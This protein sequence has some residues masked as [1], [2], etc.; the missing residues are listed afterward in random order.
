[1]EI[2]L[3]SG[4]G[5]FG[6]LYNQQNRQKN[7][8]NENSKGL[9]EES[10]KYPIFKGPEYSNIAGCPASYP[11]MYNSAVMPPMQSMD[12]NYI[13]FM[14]DQYIK[15][16]K[17]NNM[18]KNEEK[19]VGNYRKE[20]FTSAS[21]DHE[22]GPILGQGSQ[23]M[24]SMNSYIPSNDPTSE[25]LLDL[26]KRP[27]T[28][29]S[30]NNMM[31]FFGSK[32]TQNM[33]GTGVAQGN[34]IDGVTVDTGFDKSTPYQ[35]KLASFTGMDDNYLHKR[36]AGPM[37]SPG[38]QQTGWVYGTPLF[39]E[40]IGRYTDS[41]TTRN[42]LRPVESEQVGPGLNLDPSIPAAGGFHEFTRVMPNNVSDYKAN[43]L[44]GR[45]NEGKFYSAGLPTSYPGIGTENNANGNAPGVPKNRPPKDFSQTRYPTMTT[46]VG[47][48][49][50]AE[51]MRGD[52]DVDKRP[53]N[54]LRDQISYGYGTIKPV[55]TENFQNTD[56]VV[57]KPAYKAFQSS[58]SSDK[59]CVEPEMPVGI[60]PSIPTKQ[61]P[62]RSPTFM[63]QDNNIRSVSDCNSIPVIG[64]SLERHSM[65]P[66]LS[67][68]Y[69]NETGRGTVAPENVSQL[70][71]KGVDLFNNLSYRDPQKVT[72][73]ETTQFNYQGNP[74]IQD[75]QGKFY[76]YV[77]DPSVTTKETTQ[78]NYQ[79]NPNIQDK[80]GKFYTYTDLPK[81]T[82]KET[83]EFSYAGDPN[84]GLT[85][86][87]ETSRF[88]YTGP[89]DGKELFGNVDYND[90]KKMNSMG[91]KNKI[92]G[93]KTYSIKSST[94]VQDYF[95]G[96]GR[97]NILQDPDE[98]LGKIKFN[99]SDRNY[100]GP[101]TI[102]QAIP[103]ATYQQN[104]RYMA[105]PKPAANKLFGIN[106]R[107]LASYQ[108]EH[109][110]D[111]PLSMYTVNPNGE[112]P[113]FFQDNKPDDYSSLIQENKKN[114]IERVK[115][116]DNSGDFGIAVNVYPKGGSVLNNSQNNA[117]AKVVYNEISE[118]SSDS[119]SNNYN[120]M[121][122]QGSS[123]RTNTDPTFSGHAYSGEFST[124]KKNPQ[125]K[126]LLDPNGVVY[127]PNK[128]VPM[129]S[130]DFGME[131]GP[132]NT[133]NGQEVC[134]PSKPLYFTSEL[135]LNRDFR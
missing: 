119:V 99:K 30:H 23:L 79:G 5:L 9:Q 71:L 95:P 100:T 118:L 24:N 127:T 41:L 34:Y 116:V 1:M 104:N 62:T 48:V 13:K 15:Q 84:A 113:K 35:T 108:V 134:K 111:N 59:Y 83:A 88:Q 11:G 67:N 32:V 107:S 112:I 76:T 135:E 110:R 22:S 49:Q 44:E 114:I 93:A 78:F 28:D 66:I 124:D 31:P 54:A 55:N 33:A 8:Q 6:Y 132:I 89:T 47:F 19:M 39:R 133:P 36:E 37:Y 82:T 86:F 26:K 12:P 50:N 20:N 97:Q 7:F 94:L 60:S 64:P 75:K 90:L 69:V 58:K 53:K 43:Q 56:S 120:P 105:T 130:N 73:K 101:G 70:N 91:P 121:I 21:I 27:E 42:D 3:L 57:S 18:R 92:G 85:A 131:N 10:N 68:Y 106:D 65:G 109:L 125:E 16:Q 38:E 40:D 25:Y 122:S 129:Q 98:L 45:V 72:T 115:N 103:S 17:I 46:K 51:E 123:T 128:N 61:G 74:N 29:A 96:A 80:Q 87:R 117:N 77:D 102:S 14:N 81:V 52:Y 126:M 63:S 4:A 2:A